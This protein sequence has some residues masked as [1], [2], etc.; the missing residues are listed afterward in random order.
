M[1]IDEQDITKVARLAR[2][3]LQESEKQEF[4]RQL[5]DIIQYV[6]K[7]NELDTKTVE[8]ADH[9]V[10][11]KNVFRE[12]ERALSLDTSEIEKIAPH[13]E[14]GHIVVPRIIE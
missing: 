8:P 1:K 2:L 3:D 9:I 14:K 6:E 12:D 5:N 13:F 7:I 11:L 4:A 10:D